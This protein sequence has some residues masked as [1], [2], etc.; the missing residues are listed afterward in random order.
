MAYCG[1]IP[2]NL[3]RHEASFQK[4]RSGHNSR[5]AGQ[6]FR[7]HCFVPEKLKCFIHFNDRM[8]GIIHILLIFAVILLVERLIQAGNV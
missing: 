4:R 6:N 2:Q 1:E 7:R 8:E 3:G 5:R